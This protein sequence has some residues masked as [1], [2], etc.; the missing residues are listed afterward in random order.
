MASA[1]RFRSSVTSSK[2]SKPAI[3]PRRRKGRRI[4]WVL[5]A[6]LLLGLWDALRPPERQWGSR[7]ALAAI[8]F[9]QL[10][11]SHLRPGFR[12]CRF[13]PTCSNY[14]RM[15]IRR[16]GIWKGGVKTSWRLLRCGPWTEKGTVDY[17]GP[18]KG[19]SRPP[20]K[21]VDQAGNEEGGKGGS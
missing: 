8:R 3:E 11:I 15:A 14:G 16:Y 6:F 4:L 5:A 18:N 19:R 2:S 12:S 7:A 9:Y 21:G 20:K 10:E 17:P 1:S 13:R